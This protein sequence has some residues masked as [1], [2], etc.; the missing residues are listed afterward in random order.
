MK[1]IKVVN[2][3]LSLKNELNNYIGHIRG[4]VPTMGNLHAGHISLIDESLKNNDITIVTIFVN[5]TQFS[6]NEDLSNYPRTLEQDLEKI[7]QLYNEYSHKDDEKELIVFAPETNTEIYPENFSTTIS[8]GP[9]TQELEGKFRP[10]HF[11]GVTTVVF[12]LFKLT[13]PHRSYFG[14]KDLQQFI[15]IRKM[16]ADLDLGIEVNGLPIIRDTDGLALSSRNT[17]LSSEQR[18]QALELA[19]TIQE[20]KKMLEGKLDLDTINIY[21]N[22]KL[23]QDKRWNYLELRDAQNLSRDITNS[24]EVAII[25]TYQLE[26]TRLLDNAIVNVK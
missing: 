14:Q 25:G 5:P 21:I 8:L 10:T 9:I 3:K 12:L 17:Y 18:V 19:N 2:S 6:A 7:Q 24:I 13:S 20:I 15:L 22:K 23:E 16:V 26:K 1:T 11:D 4:I